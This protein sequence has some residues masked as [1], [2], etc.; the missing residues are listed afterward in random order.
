[1]GRQPVFSLSAGNGRRDH[2]GAEM[3]A[4]IILYDQH[5]PDAALFTSYDWPE[6]RIIQIPSFNFFQFHAT[7]KHFQRPISK[8]ACCS[9]LAS[10][11]TSARATISSSISI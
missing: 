4:D 10:A 9:S 6:I 7:S 11:S 8:A 3:V 1:M 2:G 5:R